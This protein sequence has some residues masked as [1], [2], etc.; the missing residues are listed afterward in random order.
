MNKICVKDQQLSSQYEP[1][2]GM[3]PGG[4]F[5]KSK[6]RIVTDINEGKA[7][8]C[9]SAIS[10]TE[11]YYKDTRT[12]FSGYGLYI[13]PNYTEL[14]SIDNIKRKEEIL[15]YDTSKNVPLVIREKRQ[16][17]KNGLI[18]L[19]YNNPELYEKRLYAGKV[20][21]GIYKITPK[22]GKIR[23][24]SKKSSIRLRKRAARIEDLSL[25]VDFTF[26]DDVLENKSITE[27]AN[28][29]YY[30]MK[31][32]I[33]YAKE[34]FGLYLIWKRENKN[35]RSGKNVGEIMPHFH[36][37]SG[38]LSEKQNKIWESICLQLLRKW[39]SITGTSNENALTVALHK[40]SYRRIE[41]PKHAMCYISKYFAKDEPI[42]IP[43]GESIGR[44]W[45]ISS[46]CPDV[47]PY[48][49]SLTQ[50]ESFKVIRHL[51]NKKKLN[52]KKGRFLK[53]QLQNGYSTFLFEDETDI[54]RYLNF[55][56][57]DMFPDA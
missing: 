1:C 6:R 4:Y 46:N 30:C 31:R 15:K 2:Y 42:E 53:R 44:C 55:I 9:I 3:A 49:V 45:G 14:S 18:F 27:R 47:A 37:L 39:V 36:V 22:R 38:G 7:P 34:K 21:P 52:S 24:V 28:F 50:K 16:A 56:G 54:G 48:V 25:W 10:E 13:Y 32:I 41:N 12:R 35:R 11:N 17:R 26:S 29:S 5:Y 57:V 51:I 40:K 20:D 19:K 23:G 8:A 33:K 43:E